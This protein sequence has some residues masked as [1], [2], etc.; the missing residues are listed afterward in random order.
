LCY[1]PYLCVYCIQSVNQF[2]PLL[3]LD[4]W[5][6]SGLLFIYFYLCMS[7]TRSGYKNLGPEQIDPLLDRSPRAQQQPM[8]DKKKDY[9]VGDP[10]KMF[11]K[12]SLA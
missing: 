5:Y 4:Q 7:P 9:G 8:G 6:Q 12:E 1:S 11:L 2:V 3:N 10:I